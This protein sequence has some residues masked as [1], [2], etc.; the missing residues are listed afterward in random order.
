VQELGHSWIDLLKIDIEGFEW[1][2][3][4]SLLS[5]PGP[6]PFTQLQVALPAP[7][8][9]LLPSLTPLVFFPKPL[10]KMSNTHTHT[11][12]HKQL[13]GRGNQELLQQSSRSSSGN[14]GSSILTTPFHCFSADAPASS[15][16]RTHR[17]H[18]LRL[19]EIQ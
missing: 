6:L 19:F 3:L 16:C 8:P 11:H 17:P 7:G 13:A 9:C 15:L 18:L 5:Q 14:G 2:V 1:E 4:E 10:K 12:E